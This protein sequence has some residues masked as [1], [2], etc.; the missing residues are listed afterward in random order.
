MKT[1]RYNDIVEKVAQLCDIAAFDLPCDVSEALKQALLRET[2]VLARSSLTQCI[3]NSRIA[4]AERIPICQDTGFAVYFVELGSEVIIEG[5]LLTDAV[6]EGTARG[7]KEAY[8]RPSIVKDPLFDRT[9]T[10]DNTPPVIHIKIVKGGTLKITLAPKG[11]GSEN[12]SAIKMFNPSD[13]ENSIKKFVVDTVVKAGGN[14]CPPTVVGIGI[15][16]TFEKAALLAKEALIRQP[17]SPNPDK[18]YADFEHSILAALNESQVGPQ[19]LGGA[20]TSFAVHI[21]TYPCH[22]AS[23]PVAVNINCHAARHASV[24]I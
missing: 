23:L 7:Y 12:C 6:T 20:T 19:G 15:G 9:N 10:G 8:L 5:G 21:E 24:E 17:G 4:A 1:I 11:A 2:G 18:R 3:E 22:I 13:N 16:G 14:P